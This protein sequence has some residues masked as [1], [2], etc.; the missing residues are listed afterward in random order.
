MLGNDGNCC[1]V[2][3]AL[4]GSEIAVPVAPGAAVAPGSVGVTDSKPTPL[5]GRPLDEFLPG[6]GGIKVLGSAGGTGSWLRPER[7]V[8]FPLSTGLTVFPLSIGLLVFCASAAAAVAVSIRT[9]NPNSMRF[10]AMWVDLQSIAQPSIVDAMI[11]IFGIARKVKPHAYSLLPVSLVCQRTNAGFVVKD[12][13]GRKTGSKLAQGG[14][15]ESS[16]ASHQC[17]IDVCADPSAASTK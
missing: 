1:I 15:R 16:A 4:P 2:E 10:A 5:Q 13:T 9:L 12:S 3:D 11:T 14:D 7:T 17:V 6:F 8:L